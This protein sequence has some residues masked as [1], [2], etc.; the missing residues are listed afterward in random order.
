MSVSSR[1]T[2]LSIQK[3]H[4]RYLNRSFFG[5]NKS[6]QNNTD[7][8]SKEAELW[9]QRTDQDFGN[10]CS[11]HKLRQ[12][13]CSKRSCGG[14]ENLVVVSIANSAEATASNVGA[15]SG[16]NSTAA[17]VSNSAEA[18]AA[19]LAAVTKANS[20]ASTAANLALV[21]TAYLVSRVNLNKFSRV[22]MKQTHPRQLQQTS[23]S[24]AISI[25]AEDPQIRTVVPDLEG[26]L[27]ISKSNINNRNKNLQHNRLKLR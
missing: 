20:A 3:Q 25:K 21:T 2:C 23:N 14:A 6:I 16:A 10:Y 5:I 22:I 27:N 13:K 11:T 12:L 8:I 4:R 7:I 18:T 1:A 15:A 24:K 9:K 26:D 19:N 17:T